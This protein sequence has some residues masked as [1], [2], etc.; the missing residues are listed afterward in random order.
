[1]QV[2]RGLEVKGTYDFYDPDWN[3]ATGARNRHGGGAAVMAS[4]FVRLEMLVRAYETES[5]R[6]LEDDDF[7]ESV[8]QLHLFY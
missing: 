2:R 8:L 6:D 7:V 3:L 4:P 5:G 1:M